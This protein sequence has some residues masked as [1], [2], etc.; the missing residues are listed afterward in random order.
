MLNGLKEHGRDIPTYLSLLAHE[1]GAL[2]R[3]LKTAT[4]AMHCFWEGEA[5]LGHVPGIVGTMPGF[6]DRTEVVQIEF[7]P[8]Q[9]TYATLLEKARGMKCA[10]TV[11]TA[12]PP[13]YTTTSRAPTSASFSPSRKKPGTTRWCASFRATVPIWRRD[14]PTIIRWAGLN[15]GLRSG[16]YDRGRF[17]VRREAGDHHFQRLLAADLAGDR[18]ESSAPLTLLYT[19]AGVNSVSAASTR[20]G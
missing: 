1:H 7:N 16:S 6:V 9:L 20:S 4:F 17:S 11:Y 18:A 3:G 15:S 10:D 13:P 5:A 2:A 8:R 12:S 19:A 14:W